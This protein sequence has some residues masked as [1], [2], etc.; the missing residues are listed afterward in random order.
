MLSGIVAKYVVVFQDR[1]KLCLRMYSF[2]WRAKIICRFIHSTYLLFYT[3][4][5]VL[6][7]YILHLRKSLVYYTHTLPVYVYIMMAVK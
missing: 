3:Y 4:I 6:Y 7:I 1:I 5:Y 2:V